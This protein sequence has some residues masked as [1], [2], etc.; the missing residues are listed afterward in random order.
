MQSDPIGLKGGINT[1]GYVEASPVLKSDMSGLS[2]QCRTGLDALHGGSL[3]PLHHEYSCWT[4]ANGKQVCRG[5]GR[6]PNSSITDAVI[7]P[8][9]GKILKDAENVSHESSTC[10]PDDKSKCMDQCLAKAWD[11]L[12]KN[13]PSYG[14]INGSSCQDV[15]R[16]I[17]ESCSRQC[18]I[19]ITP[20]FD[21]TGP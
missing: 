4:G 18:R 5:F 13:T 15:N 7:G 19:D 14:L 6:D 21:L 12:E 10:T 3:G 20:P 17:V 16:T 8:V 9:G 11:A 1:Y 2:S